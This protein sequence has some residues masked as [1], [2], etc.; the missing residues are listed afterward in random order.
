[1]R[2]ARNVLGTFITE[3]VL[4]GLNF[5][6]GVLMARMLTP[7]A[8][9]VLALAMTAPYTV[10]Y[11][12]D[13]GIVQ[14]NIYLIGRKE[15][16]AGAVVA[17]AITLAI[18]I[19]TGT[20]VILWL[21]R[22]VILRT[23]LSGLT[24][25]QFTLLLLLLPFFM[26][27][28]YMMSVL[29]AIHCFD[30]F[31]LRRLLGQLILLAAMF[32]VLVVFRK[33]ASG[34]VLAFVCASATSAVMGL[35]FVGSK[36]RLRPGLHL[37]LL[38]EA[39][40][41]GFKSYVQNLVGHLNYRLDVYLLAMFLAPAQIAFY[42]IATNIAELVWYIPDSVGTVLF[43]KLSA[44]PREHVHSMTAEVCRHTIFITALATLGLATVGWVVI[45]LFYGPAYLPAL[46]PL[47]I[48]LPGILNM[49][50]YKVLT[51]NFSSRDRQQMSILAAAV[52]LI[53]NV[54]LNLVVI[55]RY[56]IGG[57]AA[58]SLISYTVS[59]AILLIAFL[60]DSGLSWRETLVI[61]R[62]D[63]ARYVTLFERGREYAS[64]LFN[65][66]KV[67]EGVQPVGGK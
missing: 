49:A 18:V 10:T 43:P 5:I 59:A 51:R 66:G 54:G 21:A 47:F 60:R 37:G 41:Y 22:S 40:P 28:S 35:V 26:L 13:P 3:V 20:A 55:P 23:F 17:N 19:G 57:A 31:N 1:M 53:L 42:A 7:A 58:S 9:G 4:V 33:A 67:Q 61:R 11:F 32:L 63:L 65:R 24:A 12:I 48:L 62:D 14:A 56:G 8:R 50:V 64:R 29:R 45:P 39:L 6:I 36:V 25:A 16:A 52:A 27:D 44:A 2:F 30:L 34:A 46:I 15:R 38:G